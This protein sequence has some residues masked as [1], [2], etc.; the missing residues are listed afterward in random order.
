MLSYINSVFILFR[1]PLFFFISGYFAYSAIY[2]RELFKRRS[3]NRIVKQFYPTLI[4]WLVFCSIF[5]DGS[6]GNWVLDTFKGGY[7]F[8][9]VSVEMYFTII[10]FLWILSANKTSP[11]K[12][13]VY[14]L[15]LC[16]GIEF[17]Y[18][19]YIKLGVNSNFFSIMSL[20]HYFKYVPFFIMGMLVKIQKDAFN[21]L[22]S[23]RIFFIVA[24]IIFTMTVIIR[25]YNLI[26]L[27]SAVSGIIIIYSIFLYFENHKKR[28]VEKT[29]G[30]L[31]IIGTST[32]EIYLLHY[33][34]IYTFRN[35]LDLNLLASVSGSIMEFPIYF[36]IGVAICALCLLTVEIFK[37]L[38][39]HKIIF[40]SPSFI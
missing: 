26:G 25:Q 22:C 36:T 9:F 39:I 13:S 10:P 37:K 12:T 3:L 40:P 38:H 32:L 15:L 23:N 28:S 18:L 30:L 27:I 31:S 16:A 33:F 7:W 2:N 21:R 8:T 1:M 14:L 34:Y 24:L 29:F 4:L 5:Q 6:L 17:I 35:T 20:W 11:K 19:A